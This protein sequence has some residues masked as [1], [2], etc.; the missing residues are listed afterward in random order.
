MAELHQREKWVPSWSKSYRVQS[1]LLALT[2]AIR[3]RTAISSREMSSLASGS[4]S[5]S[6]DDRMAAALSRNGLR[7]GR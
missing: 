4:G 6:C 3:Y 5:G 1:P 7:T 2:A